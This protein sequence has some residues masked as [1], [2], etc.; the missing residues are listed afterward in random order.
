MLGEYD[1]GIIEYRV[2]FA[3]RDSENRSLRME[4]LCQDIDTLIAE[5]RLLWDEPGQREEQEGD[6]AERG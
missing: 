4:A 6:H 2:Q 3:R 1:L 5:V